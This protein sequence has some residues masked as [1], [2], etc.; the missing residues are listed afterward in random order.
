MS[1]LCHFRTH[2]LQQIALLFDHLGY[3]SIKCLLI[4]AQARRCA[5][6]D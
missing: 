4:A 3:P 1:V 6:N 5:V 2:A